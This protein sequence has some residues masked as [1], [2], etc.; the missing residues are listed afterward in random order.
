M[1]DVCNKHAPGRFPAFEQGPWHSW[2]DLTDLTAHASKIL[3]GLLH[4]TGVRTSHKTRIWLKPST[5]HLETFSFGGGKFTMEYLS[6][7]DFC[8]HSALCRLDRYGI[9]N[10]LFSRPSDCS[11]YLTWTQVVIWVIPL[12]VNKVWWLISYVGDSVLHYS[13]SMPQHY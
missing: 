9:L 2:L 1:S 4:R 7:A 12:V 5:R 11:S 13:R 8:N 6:W 3:G 10:A